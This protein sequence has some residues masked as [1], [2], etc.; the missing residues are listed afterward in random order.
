MYLL[1][2]LQLLL[3]N[4]ALSLSLSLLFLHFQQQ[5]QLQYPELYQDFPDFQ[6]FFSFPLHIF[7]CQTVLLKILLQVLFLYLIFSS[8]QNF[9]PY[10]FPFLRLMRQL[11][12]LDGFLQ[13]L[14]QK[15]CMTLHLYY[16]ELL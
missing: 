12:L 11:P 8:G 14:L 6:E 1:P 3:Q 5:V 9:C 7:S 13:A 10:F 2:L 4:Q 15:D 16:Q